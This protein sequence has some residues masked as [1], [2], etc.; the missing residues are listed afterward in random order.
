MSDPGPDTILLD[1]FVTNQLRERLI[2]AA[3][4]PTELP[5]EDYPIYVLV[6]AEG[7]W[8]PTALAER[9]RMP[10]STVLFRLK[11]L[12][13]RGHAERIPNPAD[14]RSHLVRLTPAGQELLANARPRFRALAE[15]VEA[16]MGAEDIAALRAG[17]DELRRAIEEEIDGDG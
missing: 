17:L 12:E 7:P 4:A 15:A 9:T 10:L 3:L 1:L 14:R 13:E 16:T 6:G 8:T 5:P 2:A 11:R